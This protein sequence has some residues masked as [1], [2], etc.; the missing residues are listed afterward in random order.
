MKEH[1]Q[2]RLRLNLFDGGGAAGG[3]GA[4][5]AASC[6]CSPNPRASNTCCSVK[7]AIMPP[8]RPMAGWIFPL[9]HA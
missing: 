4:G 9:F 8:V 2:F 7:S 5:A 6:S 3:A 1:N